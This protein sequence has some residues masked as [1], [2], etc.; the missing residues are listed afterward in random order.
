MAF[1]SRIAIK[2]LRKAQKRVER[3]NRILRTVPRSELTNEQRQ[4]LKRAG[5][6]DEALTTFDRDPS[7]TEPTEGFQLLDPGSLESLGT[8]RVQTDDQGR[9]RLA[10]LEG[11]RPDRVR[12]RDAV[13][14]P[15]PDSGF[16]LLPGREVEE[17]PDTPLNVETTL[18]FEGAPG[19]QDQERQQTR[20]GIT[21]TTLL[22]ILGALF[23]LR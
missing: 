11:S 6:L 13:E 21:T 23:L 22:L 10:A 19:F 18:T 9:Q 8:F 7:D 5:R 15:E 20:S 4:L 3:I 1:G 14:T 16:N 12:Q 2:E 17:R